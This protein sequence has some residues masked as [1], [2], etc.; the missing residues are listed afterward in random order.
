[1]RDIPTDFP[2]SAAQQRVVD[3]VVTG[4]ELIAD[5]LPNALTT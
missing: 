2:L 1:M 3:V 5:G 4:R